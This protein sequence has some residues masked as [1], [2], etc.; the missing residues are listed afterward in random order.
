MR[1]TIDAEPGELAGLPEEALYAIARAAE[2]DGADRGEW[3]T[4][5]LAGAG[6]RAVVVPVSREP[7]YRVVEDVTRH[8]VALHEMAATLM[9]EAIRERLAR[10]L[11]AIPH[12]AYKKLAG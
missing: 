12:G 9:R 5:A 10:E 2:A 4:K 1:I 3:L 6:A 11:D 8:A 7:K